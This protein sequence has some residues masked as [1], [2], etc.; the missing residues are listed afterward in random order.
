MVQVEC[1]LDHDDDSF[2]DDC[3]SNS[4]VFRVTSVVILLLAV[5]A[6]FSLCYMPV[7]D[8]FWLVKLV[9]VIGASI[10]LLVPAANFFDDSSFIFVSRIGGLVFIVFMQ[11]ILLD[12]A[13]YW[14]K[15]WV[16]DTTATGRMTNA[17]MRGSDLVNVMQ[18]VW[19]CALT[20]FSV[21]YIVVFV[22]AMSIMLSFFGGSGCSDNETIISISM[23]LVIGALVIQL[24]L[25]KNGSI[26]ASGILA[27]YGKS[28]CVL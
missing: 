12:F 4:S 23:V 11:T 25:S 3:I 21:A 14:K 16:D 26:I 28:W 17:S 15:S 5:Q 10:G 27:S 18:N 13:Y 8:S 7:Y 1:D 20:L 2:E 19:V 22:V 9:Y 6:I 24:F